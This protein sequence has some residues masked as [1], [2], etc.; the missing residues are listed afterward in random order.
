MLLEMM[1]TAKYTGISL[2]SIPYQ[3]NLCRE[4][5]ANFFS[6]SKILVDEKFYP[7]NTREFRKSEAEEK[8]TSNRGL[9]GIKMIYLDIL[10][11]ETSSHYFNVNIILTDG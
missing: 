7:A 6:T 11:I 3:G 10:H 4:K 2:I 9:L 1:F 5:V 8:M